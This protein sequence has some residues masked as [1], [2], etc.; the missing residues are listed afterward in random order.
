MSK[1]ISSQSAFH[2]LEK[3]NE[4]FVHGRPV[5]RPDP[6]ELPRT[7]PQ[8]VKKPLLKKRAKARSQPARKAPEAAEKETEYWRP[9]GG[10]SLAAAEGDNGPTPTRIIGL[11]RVSSWELHSFKTGVQSAV[12]E[13]GEAR[14]LVT[15]EVMDGAEKCVDVYAV[16]RSE[17]AAEVVKDGLHGKI[18]QGRAL[19][20]RYA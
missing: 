7:T 18:V 10:D 17:L 14:D 3:K 13:Y 20:V 6:G 8:K 16:F 5:I 1:G 19:Q 9:A 12:Q 4:R 2:H 11:A 15:Q